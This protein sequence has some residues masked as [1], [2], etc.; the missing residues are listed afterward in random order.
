MHIVLGLYEQFSESLKDGNPA[1]PSEMAVWTNKN[2][3]LIPF[4]W[5]Q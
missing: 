4:V 5:E 2:N 3:C 1:C